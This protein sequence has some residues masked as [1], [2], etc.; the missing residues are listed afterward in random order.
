METKVTVVVNSTEEMKK[1]APALDFLARENWGKPGLF[2]IPMQ[3]MRKY[4]FPAPG[5]AG[6]F[7]EA[8]VKAGKAQDIDMAMLSNP[9]VMV[10]VADGHVVSRQP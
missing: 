7:R 8:L 3:P 2:Q 5:L 9:G 6:Y 10:A 4:S 1:L